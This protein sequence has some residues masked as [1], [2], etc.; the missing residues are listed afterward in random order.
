MDITIEDWIDAVS[1]FD[2]RNCNAPGFTVP[3]LSEKTG[4]CRDT[5]RKK[6]KRLV[7]EGKCLAGVGRRIN[8]VGSF[9]YPNVYELIMEEKD[10]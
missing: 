5:I 10:G 1:E 8:S 2:I 9:Y 6:L 3:E 4:R 7:K